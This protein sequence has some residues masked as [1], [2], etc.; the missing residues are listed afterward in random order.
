MHGAIAESPIILSDGCF[1]LKADILVLVRNYFG[2]PRTDNERGSEFLAI[3][4]IL[5]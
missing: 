4:A 3:R 1:I 5:Q 2:R